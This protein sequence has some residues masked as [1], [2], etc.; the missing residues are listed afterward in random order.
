MRTASLAGSRSEDE[1]RER[2][3]VHV[4]NASHIAV[5]TKSLEDH[6]GCMAMRERSPEHV[7]EAA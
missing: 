3:L 2:S 1:A 7:A 5:S 4:L 6:G